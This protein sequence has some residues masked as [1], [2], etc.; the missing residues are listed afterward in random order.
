MLCVL[1]GQAPAAV[2]PDPASAAPGHRVTF[3]FHSAFL[4]NLHHFLYDMAVHK[5]KIAGVPWQAAPSESEMRVLVK[6]IDFYRTRYAVLVLLDD[7]TMVGI[8]RALSVDD[9]RRHAA[10]L[11]LPPDLASVL[12][13][14]AP[15]Y[16]RYLWPVHN[17][18]NRAWIARASELDASYGAE[19]QAAV[20]RDLEASFPAAPIRTDVVFD[21]GS[22]QGAYTD[23]QTVMPS[24]RVDY[25]GLASLEMLYHEASHTTV[26][27]PLEEQIGAQLK[28]THRNEDSDLWHVVQ[29][30]TVGEATRKVLERHG[31]PGY[32]PYADKR[33][34]YTGYWSP[35]MPAVREVWPRHLAGQ[36]GLHE[37]AR[38]MVDRLPAQ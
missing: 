10:G 3:A 38:E 25:Q 12:E 27:T 28:A 31:A 8:K 11:G 36:I 7:P 22:R 32:Q 35:L 19:V 1:C 20:E 29:F 33:G 37:A 5:D 15:V 21:T 34:L 18:S 2:L 16:D 9:D 30:Y 17:Q 14:V 13:E 26:T 23:E 24:A 6:A 4:M